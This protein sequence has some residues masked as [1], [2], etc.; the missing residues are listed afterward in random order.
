MDK[1]DEELASAIIN[2]KFDLS[3]RIALTLGKRTLE[4]YYSKTDDTEAYRICMSKCHY[5][6]HHRIILTVYVIVL[7]P[8]YKRQYF[9]SAKWEPAWIK[10]AEDIVR[11]Q[12]EDKYAM[13][14]VEGCDETSDV[15]EDGNEV[16]IP[17]S[18]LQRLRFN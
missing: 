10:T 18:L 14:L 15:V 6:S 3:I 9:E 8:Q 16:S 7:H 17:L 13:R 1:I 4:R 11:T 12:W 5:S 2:P